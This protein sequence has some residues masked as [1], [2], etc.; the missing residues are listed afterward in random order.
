MVAPN[1]CARRCAVNRRRLAQSVS[2]RRQYLQPV[3]PCRFNLPRRVPWSRSEPPSRASPGSLCGRKGRCAQA[4]GS[5]RVCAGARWKL[6]S[7]LPLVGAVRY[8]WAINSGEAECITSQS[9]RTHKCVRALR[10]RAS[11]APLISDVMPQAALIRRL[12][13]REMRKHPGRLLLSPHGRSKFVRKAMRREPPPSGAVGFWPAPVSAARHSL[14]L[15]FAT[16]RPMV[17]LGTAVASI[18]GFSVWAQRPLRT[19][20]RFKHALCRRALEARIHASHG[21]RGS[22]SLRHQLRGGRVHNKSIE[23]DA[24][25]RSCASRPRFLCAAHFRRYTEGCS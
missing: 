15:Q 3:T 7:M 8:P 9:R 22:V 12:F 10:A 13:T 4:V 16:S 6:A 21:R 18:A 25:V 2:G 19:G 1:S 23:T 14:P 24:Q 20:C 11:C 17:T 5:G